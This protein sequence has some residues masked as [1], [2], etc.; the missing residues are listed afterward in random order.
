MLAFTGFAQ[1]FAD[2]SQRLQAN[3]ARR[4]ELVAE[5]EKL[6]AEAREL[7]QLLGNPEVQT[8]IQ[9]LLRVAEEPAEGRPVTGP[10]AQA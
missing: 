2:A 9:R 3:R 10:P 1:R 6:D 5:I 4:A 7:G 8:L